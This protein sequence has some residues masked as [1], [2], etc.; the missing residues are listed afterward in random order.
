MDVEYLSQRI[1]LLMEEFFTNLK[2]AKKFLSCKGW[3]MERGKDLRSIILIKRRAENG[4]KKLLFKIEQDINSLEDVR[5]LEKM[6]QDL[7]AHLS[8][9]AHLHCA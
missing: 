6:L 2:Y 3:I 4:T 1:E 8:K 9:I 5:Y 7:A